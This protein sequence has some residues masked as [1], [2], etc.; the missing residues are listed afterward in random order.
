M[1]IYCK[2]A[3][4]LESM[5][6]L[7][8]RCNYFSVFI[9]LEHEEREQALGM[10]FR[11]ETAMKHINACT[12][13]AETNIGEEVKNFRYDAK[14]PMEKFTS[15]KCIRENWIISGDRKIFKGVQRCKKDVIIS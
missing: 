1:C 11:H 10:T 7:L 13:E 14:I 6:F 5:H 8:S 12:K 3:F 4:S 2:D 15:K 9:N